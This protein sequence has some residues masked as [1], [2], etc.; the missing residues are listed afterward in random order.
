MNADAF[1]PAI[2]ACWVIVPVIFYG[3]SL[4]RQEVRTGIE[5]KAA[6]PFIF[7]C[8]GFMIV[9]WVA[10]MRLESLFISHLLSILIGSLIGIGTAYFAI[11]I[12]LALRRERS[13]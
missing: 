3:I 13:R 12:A 8:I 10:E 2:V 1:L 11:R 6:A 4:S 7:G 9:L 5:P